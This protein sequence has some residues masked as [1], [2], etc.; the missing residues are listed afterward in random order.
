MKVKSSKAKGRRLQDWVRTALINILD[1]PHQDIKCAIMGEGGID[2]NIHHS[3]LSKFPYNI[4]CKNVERINIWKAWEQCC[5][6]KG[7]G[8]PLL[9][10]SKNRH[11]PLIVIDA[12]HFI[13]LYINGRDKQNKSRNSN[14]RNS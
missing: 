2:V 9:F 5:K 14:P 12:T 11:S 6:H 8:H 3:S 10:L 1:I 13:G 7:Q 4:E